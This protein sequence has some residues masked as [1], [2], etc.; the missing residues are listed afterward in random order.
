MSRFLRIALAAVAAAACAAAQ[1]VSAGSLRGPLADGFAVARDF[2][3]KQ[4]LEIY[5]FSTRLDRA[6]R[7]TLAARTSWSDTVVKEVAGTAPVLDLMFFFQPEATACDRSKLLSYTAVFRKSAAFPFDAATEKPM[8]FVISGGNYGL[9]QLSCGFATGAPVR[10]KVK[11]S[12][13]ATRGMFPELLPPGRSSLLFTWDVD[14][15]G[16]IDKGR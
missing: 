16:R 7:A 15:T 12:W 4:C 10:I 9:S 11:R 3:G 14:F 5:F 1:E 13:D 2:F 6:A 8:N